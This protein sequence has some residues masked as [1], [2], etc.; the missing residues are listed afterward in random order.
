MSKVNE[1]KELVLQASFGTVT[2]KC[3]CNFFCNSSFKPTCF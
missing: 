2:F 3:N 1:N